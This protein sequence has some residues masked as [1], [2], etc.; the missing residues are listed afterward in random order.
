MTGLQLGGDKEIIVKAY[1]CDAHNLVILDMVGFMMNERSNDGAKEKIEKTFEKYLQQY[2]RATVILLHKATEEL[3]NNGG[4]QIFKN[5]RNK[6]RQTD[7]R[8]L[9]S[10]FIFNTYT[11]M[12]LAGGEAD[13][14]NRLYQMMQKGY[15]EERIPADHIF[16]GDVPTVVEDTMGTLR[17]LTEEETL[18]REAEALENLLRH[19]PGF[20]NFLARLG[21]NSFRSTIRALQFQQIQAALLQSASSARIQKSRLQGKLKGMPP[22]I[23]QDTVRGEFQQLLSGFVKLAAEE[24]DLIG[25]TQDWHKPIEKEILHEAVVSELKVFCAALIGGTSQGGTNHSPYV[26][27]FIDEDVA[28]K[29]GKQEPPMAPFWFKDLNLIQGIAEAQLK[30]MADRYSARFSILVDREFGEYPALAKGLQGHL[31][32]TIN[33]RLE[34]AMGITSEWVIQPLRYDLTMPH[35][36]WGNKTN[37]EAIVSEVK[38]ELRVVSLNA[39]PLL[40]AAAAAVANSIPAMSPMGGVAAAIAANAL[41]AAAQ[42]TASSAG[43]NDDNSNISNLPIASLRKLFSGQRVQ[44]LKISDREY[45]FFLK[46]TVYFANYIIPAI[47]N[48]VRAV[49]IRCFFDFTTADGG[50]KAERRAPLSNGQS[51]PPFPLWSYLNSV[52][53]NRQLLNFMTSA[54]SVAREKQRQEL[55]QDI[56]VLGKLIGEIEGKEAS[57]VD[58]ADIDADGGGSI[59]SGD[60]SVGSGT[61]LVGSA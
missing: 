41:N 7:L 34:T 32:Q 33:S 28:N 25:A 39:A 27:T 51:F 4:M 48:G 57:E 37:I 11:S 49:A 44:Q 30:A 46:L 58:D 15:P 56:D 22:L 29:L 9:D 26:P 6:L 53:N 59:S 54:G 40:P 35:A 38:A 43:V 60:D 8:A 47:I 17:R 36:S 3:S 24:T 52:Y 23:T 1:G 21:M 18:Q 16:A 2:P 5:V 14:A 10:V 31:A 61:V 42:S 45:D 20:E 50:T 12:V 55:Q 13:K 19:K